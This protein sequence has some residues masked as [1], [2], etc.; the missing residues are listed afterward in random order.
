MSLLE[1]ILGKAVGS[2]LGGGDDEASSGDS[3][4]QIVQLLIPIVVALLANGGLEK[5][6]G[7]MKK[8]GLAAEADSWVGDGEN[9]PITGE[10]AAQVIGEDEVKKIAGEIGVDEG[11]AAN[12]IAKALPQ[13]VDKV[14]PEG[15]EPVADAVDKA[16]DSL[17][18]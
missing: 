2:A 13:V 6:L 1:D 18:G 14:S 12:L 8:Q 7:G 10:Q 11:Q 15:T 16:L 4:S 17:K 5:I 9:L 3:K